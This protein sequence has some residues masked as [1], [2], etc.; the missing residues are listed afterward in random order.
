MVQSLVGATQAAEHL[1]SPLRGFVFCARLPTVETV[2]YVVVRTGDMADR[3]D[4][5]DS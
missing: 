2:G 3:I 1:V 5:G 4:R